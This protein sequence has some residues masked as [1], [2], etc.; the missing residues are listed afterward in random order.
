MKNLGIL[1]FPFMILS[2]ASNDKFSSLK[3]VERLKT[4]EPIRDVILSPDSQKLLITTGAKRYLYNLETFSFDAKVFF[5]QMS[6]NTVNVWSKDSQAIFSNAVDGGVLI[7]TI[8]T[9]LPT[10]MT[11]SLSFD[12]FVFN[13]DQ[14]AFVGLHN[15]FSLAAFKDN[16]TTSTWKAQTSKFITSF[17]SSTA[18]NAYSTQI[19]NEA[20]YLTDFNSGQIMKM[21]QGGEANTFSK[22]GLTWFVCVANTLKAFKADSG[23]EIG[24]VSISRGCSALAVNASGTLLAKANSVELELLDLKSGRV[25]WKMDKASLP[26]NTTL[27]ARMFFTTDGKYL[28]TGFVGT[29]DVFVWGLI[30]KAPVF[31]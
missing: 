5:D 16:L 9:Q 25:L 23:T 29:Q 2:C 12:S 20:A 19:R 27:I 31:Q 18:V 7:N 1:I 22:D 30:S 17:A 13:F 11:S 10:K 21:V 8:G 15:R 28:V 6:Q 3:I 26:V 24:S 14:S 4:P